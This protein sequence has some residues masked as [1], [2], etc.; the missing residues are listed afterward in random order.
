MRH[1]L[2]SIQDGTIVTTVRTGLAELNILFQT[3]HH[4]RLKGP[5]KYAPHDSHLRSVHTIS[6]W[7]S[8]TSARDTAKLLGQPVF[9]ATVRRA[10]YG[11]LSLYL[12]LTPMR[13][14]KETR[15]P[16][17]SRFTLSFFPYFSL[18]SASFFP[19]TVFYPT[20]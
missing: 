4:H 17:L 3:D 2:R 12:C 1:F 8:A 5:R 6:T 19:L 20:G 10:D 9:T 14:P 11:S 13:I 16:D 15:A 18:W 7:L